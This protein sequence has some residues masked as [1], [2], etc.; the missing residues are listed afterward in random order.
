ML[1]GKQKYW[2]NK[3]YTQPNVPHKENDS[4]FPQ[5]EEYWETV[6]IVQTTHFD[7]SFI[8]VEHIPDWDVQNVLWFPLKTG[9]MQSH[10]FS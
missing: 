9:K 4:N 5:L 2:S 7:E 1:L 10:T 8:I 3:S 6:K